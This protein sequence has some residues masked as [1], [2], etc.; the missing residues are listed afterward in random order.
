MRGAYVNP[1][2][3]LRPNG[4]VLCHLGTWIDH[5]HPE[6][7][8]RFKQIPAYARSYNPETKVWTVHALYAGQAIAYLREAFPTLRVERLREHGG[9]DTPPPPPRQPL[10]GERHF[11][12]LC[13][14]PT[15]PPEVVNAAYRAWV[16]LAH[17]DALPAPERD[18]AHRRMV[19][20][21]A[22]YEALRAEGAA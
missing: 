18:R 8:R 2:A 21:N 19:E 3:M 4:D 11:A 1:A 6:L 22:A 13:L 16:K 9:G 17:P 12:A 15:A 5:I 14:L 7:V 10:T 20:I